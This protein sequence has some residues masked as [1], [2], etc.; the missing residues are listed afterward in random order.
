MI[1]FAKTKIFFSKIEI[2]KIFRMVI[3]KTNS[4]LIC[5]NFQVTQKPSKSNSFE[6]NNIH[7]IGGTQLLENVYTKSLNN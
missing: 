5:C 7:N 2:Y 1:I 3:L 4:D 6:F